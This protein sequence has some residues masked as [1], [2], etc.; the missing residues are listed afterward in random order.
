MENFNNTVFIFKH[1][2]EVPSYADTVQADPHLLEIS[3]VIFT[4]GI[5]SNLFSAQT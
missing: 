5:Q 2:V 4:H 3:E 1:H